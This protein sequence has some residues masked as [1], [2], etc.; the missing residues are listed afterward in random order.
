[1]SAHCKPDTVRTLA[2]NEPRKRVS[3]KKDEKAEN[4]K[5]SFFRYSYY[6]KIITGLLF[7]C[8]GD[9]FLLWPEYFELGMIA[10]AL[11]HVNYIMAFGFKPT[12]LPLGICLYL[13]DLAGLFQ[14][15]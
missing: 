11:G 9:A 6:R 13:T 1:M 4:I 12:N 3:Y 2:R 15:L 5:H 7:C 10:F 8:V 14:K